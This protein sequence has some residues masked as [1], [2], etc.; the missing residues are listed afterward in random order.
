MYASSC[1]LGKYLM[2]D[3]IEDLFSY[4]TKIDFGAIYLSGEEKN[5]AMNLILRLFC[6]ASQCLI[7]L[8]SMHYCLS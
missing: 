6:S 5:F 2:S 3:K 8:K 7:R 1:K 4:C